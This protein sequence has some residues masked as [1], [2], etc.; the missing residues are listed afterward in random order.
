MDYHA[1]EKMT[2]AQLRDEAKKHP[3]IAGAAGMKKEQL[4]EA[5]AHQLGLEKPAARAKKEKPAET[6]D[7]ASLKKKI[8]DLKAARDTARGGKDKKKASILR[9]RI[10]SLKRRMGKVA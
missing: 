8:V 4:L 3:D 7:K 2:V 1:F 10:H 6:L 9:R 5:L